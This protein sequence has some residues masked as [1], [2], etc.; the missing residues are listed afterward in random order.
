MLDLYIGMMGRRVMFFDRELEVRDDCRYLH[1]YAVLS[2]DVLRK[3]KYRLEV[4]KTL[5][6]TDLWFL[7]WHGLGWGGANHPF[8]VD[9]CREVQEGPRTRTVDEWARGHGK[10]TCITTGESIQRILNNPEER[11]AIFSYS[12]RA[13]RKFFHQIK[14]T[15]E[16]NL[17]LKQCFPDILYQDPQREA[18]KW[19]E[20]GGIFVK[21][22]GSYKEAT[23]E[24][25]GLL[26]SMPT[27][28]H[29]TGR[30]YDDI[31]TEDVANSPELSDRIK[32][33]FDLSLNLGTF[34]DDDW[35]RVIGT[36]YRVGDVLQFIKDKRD[37]ISGKQIYFSRQKP[38]TEGGA[39]NGRSVFLPEHILAEARS[40][41]RKFAAQQLVNPSP[42][43]DVKL[44][45][46]LIRPIEASNIPSGLIK[47][48]TI[49]PAGQRESETQEGDSWAIMAFGVENALDDL[50]AINFYILD[51]LIK[52]MTIDE[53]L[54]AVFE[55]YERNSRIRKI[56]IEKV[57]MSTM[58]IHL[59]NYMRS[60][61][62]I[63]TVENKGLEILKPAGRDKVQRIED[64]LL[65]P[66]VNS[67]VYMS[68]AVPLSERERLRLEMERF[69]HWK[70]DGVD[71]WAYGYD[72]L[73]NFRF[74]RASSG[75]APR[76]DSGHGVRRSENNCWVN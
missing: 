6:L 29:F 53:A 2:D 28:S 66:L 60:K 1:D 38:A 10:S 44:D 61:G 75:S 8:I 16:D 57:G 69:P 37:P 17:Y 24:G 71:S 43:E 34:T 63:M 49:D 19:S 3:P 73:R 67:K 18:Y 39:W 59:A 50:G 35:V 51:L 12:A 7:V 65:W 46:R 15:F 76:R 54:K 20:E 42:L 21:R 13:S 72:M 23:V 74:S 52:V 32:E 36:P 9:A 22:K 64:A 14:R 25:F 30:I 55:M 31:L 45:Y 56:G 11:I 33:L 70:D 5:Y 26:D 68:S 27:G 4:L 48:M 47:F 41:R 58:E 40:N 62:R